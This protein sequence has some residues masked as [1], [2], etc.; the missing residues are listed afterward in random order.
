MS[1]LI[2]LG[3]A[4][5]IPDRDHENTHMVIAGKHRLILIDGPANPYSRIL[6][7]GLNPD[8]LTDI[9]LTHFH[10]DHVGGIPLLLM[11]LGLSGRKEDLA[12]YA[13]EHCMTRMLDLLEAFDWDK[14]HSFNVNI[15][16]LPEE[17]MHLLLE[18]Q[19]LRI[20]ASPVKHFIP[21]VGLRIELQVQGKV[22]A[23]TG[24]TA[25]IE[26]LTAL[27]DRADILIH[28]AAG[29]SEG[30]SSARQAG[31]FAAK[32]GVGALY[33]VHYPVGEHDPSKLIAEASEVFQGKIEVPVDFDE[34]DFDLI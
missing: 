12:I 23:Y 4:T 30:H 10:P 28:E 24:D 34:L 7:A 26:T 9:V 16:L 8:L 2:F 17:E 33:F 22:I 11:A 3:T 29:A 21:A 6:Q 14:W 32:M 15:H 25:P 18:D 1:K 13:N 19:E 27:T 20:F 5:N 31:I